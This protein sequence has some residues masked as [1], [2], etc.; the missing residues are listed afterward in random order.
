MSM[1]L[2]WHL[3]NMEDPREKGY[4]SPSLSLSESQCSWYILL[5]R[6]RGRHKQHGNPSGLQYQIS[7]FEERIK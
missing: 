5:H 6:G 2:P 3:Q 4:L 7:K 1:L